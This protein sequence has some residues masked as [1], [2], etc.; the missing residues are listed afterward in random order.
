MNKTS[1]KCIECGE[2]TY[3]IQVIDLVLKQARVKPL[4]VY[5]D[6]LALQ[7]YALARDVCGAFDIDGDP[8]PNGAYDLGADEYFPR[9]FLPLTTKPAEE[10]QFLD[11]MWMLR[12]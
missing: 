6:R 4:C 2:E 5:R 12:K 9:I 1:R 8:R 11:S 10:S 7:R 3:A